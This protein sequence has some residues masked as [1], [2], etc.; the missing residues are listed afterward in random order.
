MGSHPAQ[1]KL[2]D[3]SPLAAVI[4]DRELIS[5][6]YHFQHGPIDIIATLVGEQ[7]TVIA[8]AEVAWQ[9]FRLVL[10]ELVAELQKLRLPIVTEHSTGR[11]IEHSIAVTGSVAQRMVRA[12][13]PFAEQFITPMAAV[14][15]SVADELLEALLPCG[16][17]K[18]I[19]NNGGDISLAA[20]PGQSLTVQLLA[21]QGVVRLSHCQ[22]RNADS[23][24]QRF[25]VATSGWSGRSFSLG[26]ADAVSV[27]AATASQADAA[28]TMIA[29]SVGCDLQ[30]QSIRRA[31][32]NTLKDDTDLG[33]RLVTTGV[34][35]LDIELINHELS[36]GA[37]FAH[38]CL[39]DGKILAASLSL[40]GESVIV[41]SYDRNS[42]SIH[43]N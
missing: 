34:G 1:L 4:G 14:A 18:I 13:N 12:V 8:A 19:I 23:G 17:Q 30:H 32:A 21:P 22:S 29:N 5:N 25:G 16:L 36:R 27:V 3:S 38:S 6:R 31:P 43:A 42:K 24:W 40:Q 2:L 39:N 10:P 35:P 41:Q 26:I 28:A 33:S 20:R 11:S 37:Q 9:R 15:G 7:A